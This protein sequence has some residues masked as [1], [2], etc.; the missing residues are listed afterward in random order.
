MTTS[1]DSDDP[2]SAHC[3]RDPLPGAGI[4]IV[5]LTELPYEQAEGVIAPLSRRIAELGRPVEHRII[6]VAGLNLA[7]ALRRGIEDTHMPLVL[8][9]TAVK[10]WS[11]KHVDPL[12]EAIDASDHVIGR[13]PKATRDRAANWMTK[14]VRRLIFAV[15]LDDV[16]SPCRLH[17]LDKLLA[18]VL[19]SKSSFLDT[20]IL[21]K[22]TF[23]GQLISE[24]DVPPLPGQ[25]W[26]AGWW[27]D[28]NQLFKHPQFKSTSSPPEEAE[29][30]CER[31]DRPRGEDRHG[32]RHLE[33]TGTS[34]DH[35]AQGVDELSQRQCAD[36]ALQPTG[37]ASGSEEYAGEQPHRQHDQVHQAADGL[38]GGGAAAD[39][40][41]DPGKG[42]C[43]QH[44]NRDDEGE[45]AADRHLEHEGPKQEQDRQVGEDESQSRAQERQ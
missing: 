41:P 2:F 5:I 18:V 45:I 30:E 12:L 43:S 20:E 31:D 39:E 33:R 15:P 28:W 35:H 42:E 10:P 7:E 6:A 44:F 29:R 32:G 8:V 4:R 11:A 9:T 40:Q 25:S 1:E 36:D 14:L 19:Q 22:A 13:R 27:S 24:V 3:K 37:K 26:N 38:G 23:L 34:E 21:A 17:R 16:H